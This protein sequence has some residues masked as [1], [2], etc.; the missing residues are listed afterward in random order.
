M[1]K[2]FL[3]LIIFLQIAALGQQSDLSKSVNNLTGFISS[4]YFSNLKKGTNDLSLVDTIYEHAVKLKNYNY[5]EALLSLTFATIPYNVVPLEIPFTHVVMNF[6]LISDADSIFLL[7]NKALPKNLLYDSPKDSFGDKDKM[8]HFFG[9]AFIAYDS[10]FF[11][12]ADLIGYFVE[13][14]EETFVVQGTVDFRDLDVDKMGKLFGILLKNNKNLL[15]SDIFLSRSL[16]N[17][18]YAP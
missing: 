1:T 2:L 16:F 4:D 12:F 6:P 9:S 17:F 10:F 3:L 11:D 15:P 8:A 13:V 7:K 5:S 18:R 14:F